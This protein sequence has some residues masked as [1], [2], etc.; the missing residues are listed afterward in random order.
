MSP[1]SKEHE[2]PSGPKRQRTNLTRSNPSRSGRQD[3]GIGVS[4]TVFQPVRDRAA[5]NAKCT[6][7][8]GPFQVSHQAFQVSTENPRCAQSSEQPYQTAGKVISCFSY[9]KVTGFCPTWWKS[10]D[11]VSDTFLD[12]QCSKGCN[13]NTSNETDKYAESDE[14]SKNSACGECRQDPYDIPSDNEADDLSQHA[15]KLLR[16]VHIPKSFHSDPYI[17]API[18]PDSEVILLDKVSNREAPSSR[19]TPDSHRTPRIRGS[20]RA[21]FPS[22]SIV[23]SLDESAG[24]MPPN[25]PSPPSN[26][27]FEKVGDTIYARTTPPRKQPNV[28][29]ISL[30]SDSED[31]DESA[32]EEAS[33]ELELPPTTKVAADRAQ[34]ME[35]MERTKQYVLTGSPSPSPGK[36][37]SWAQAAD[38]SLGTAS[39]TTF[40]AAGGRSPLSAESQTTSNLIREQL[41]ETANAPPS[42]QELAAQMSSSPTKPS[43]GF[44]GAFDWSKGRPNGTGEE[45]SQSSETMAQMALKLLYSQDEERFSDSNIVDRSTGP[46]TTQVLRSHSALRSNRHVGAD[47]KQGAVVPLDET[48]PRPVE[49]KPIEELSIGNKAELASNDDKHALSAKTGIAVELPI[50]TAKQRTQ[51][52]AVSLDESADIVSTGQP[53]DNRP[54]AIPKSFQE[55]NGATSTP[56]DQSQDSD[57]EALS[58]VLRRSPQWLNSTGLEVESETEQNG[59]AATQAFTLRPVLRAKPSVSSLLPHASTAA[60]DAPTPAPR[61]DKRERETVSPSRPVSIVPADES[62]RENLGVATRPD[63]VSCSKGKPKEKFGETHEEN[64]EK[65]FEKF[66]EQS[67]QK[68]EGRPAQKRKLEGLLPTSLKSEGVT[69]GVQPVSGDNRKGARKTPLPDDVPPQKPSDHKRRKI[70]HSQG[71]HPRGQQDASPQGK[72]NHRNKPRRRNFGKKARAQRR[73]QRLQQTQPQPQPH[74]NP[75]PHPLAGHQ[76]FPIAFG[77]ATST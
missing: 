36:G 74:P 60:D 46:Q 68:F 38:K 27:P 66:E 10:Q 72:K 57:A 15:A 39:I 5:T 41:L 18:S 8:Q 51:Y 44:G 29:V 48:R 3:G 53:A 50:L 56:G 76:Q 42:N 7:Y 14:R 16:K 21:R 2:P 61:E 23:I 59:N 6:G 67:S 34:T 69:V 54:T 43:A 52:H 73:Q 64:P 55:I 13:G 4:T 35:R 47:G 77:T 32:S 65:K 24:E 25:S 63:Q 20:G 31:S 37:A 58:Y 71:H 75:H 22:G 45:N 11:R 19:A 28:R 33:R 17:P 9:S 62:D 30:S 26:P 1:G 40:F 12:D 49:I 70:S